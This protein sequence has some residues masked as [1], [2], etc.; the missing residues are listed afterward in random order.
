MQTQQW[1]DLT[2]DGAVRYLK[3]S[4]GL[5]KANSL[6]LR[7]DGG[8]WLVVSPPRDASP[9]VFD[10]L[11]KDGGVAALV[12]PNAYHNLGQKPWRE[13]FPDAVSY[14]PAGA[15]P[16]L[17]KKAPG[18]PF[19]PL[20]ALVPKLPSHIAI[21]APD[22]MKLPEVLLHATTGGATVWFSGDLISNTGKADM[23]LGGR[24]IFKLLGG[25]DGYRLNRVPAMVYVKDKKAWRASVKAAFEANPPTIVVPGH[26]DPVTSD[27]AART[28]ALFS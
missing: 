12:A 2:P 11:G 3:Y 19:Q 21:V 7:L 20:D 9:E 26:G 27:A 25:G 28:R 23:G 16:R 8:A 13:R 4:F 10:R 18:V 24:I 14:A 6:A 15:L 17:A 5:G 22:G 1:Q